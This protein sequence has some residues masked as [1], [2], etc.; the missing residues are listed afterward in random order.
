MSTYD[1]LDIH[2]SDRAESDNAL[3]RKLDRETDEADFKWLMSSKRGRRIIWRLLNRAGVFRS[4]WNT[5]SMTM[6]F[7]EGCKNEGYRTLQHI[8]ALCPELYSVMVKENANERN[9]DDGRHN[10]H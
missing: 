10:D 2:A 3:L 8:H 4:S 1:P 6:A 9:T 5:N 7:T